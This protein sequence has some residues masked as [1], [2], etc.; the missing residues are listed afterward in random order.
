MDVKQCICIEIKNEDKVF[1]FT[2]PVGATWGNAIDAA[3]G[4]LDYVSKQSQ[5]SVSNAKPTS[6]SAATEPT[7]EG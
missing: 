4:F 7:T 6:I 1:T 5:E 3:F 2:L